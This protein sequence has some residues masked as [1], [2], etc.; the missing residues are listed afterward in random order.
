M[1]ATPES[2]GDLVE[3]NRA[4]CACYQVPGHLRPCLRCES[5][6]AIE[7]LQAERDEARAERDSY[8][9]ILRALTPAALEQ[10]N[11]GKETE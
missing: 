9:A 3:R 1:T 2:A 4:A 8:A 11:D 7:R 10:A 6:A 5:A